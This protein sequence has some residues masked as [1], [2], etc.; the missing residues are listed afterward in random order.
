MQHMLIEGLENLKDERASQLAYKWAER[1]VQSN[2]IAFR[3]TG[4]MYEKYIATEFG[5]HGGG[6]EYE[7]QK[8]FGWSN[9]AVLDLL[10]RYGATLK[11]PGWHSNFI[12][13]IPPMHSL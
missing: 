10:N 5:G 12:E 13:K 6:G 2:Y 11:S 7:V 3:D 1:W 8:G 9:G 4:A